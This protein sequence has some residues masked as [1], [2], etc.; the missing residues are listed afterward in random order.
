MAIWA[1]HQY[2][3]GIAALVCTLPLALAGCNV[4]RSLQIESEQSTGDRIQNWTAAQQNFWSSASQGSR[5]IPY[6]WYQALEQ[7]GSKS[8]FKQRAHL[9]RFNYPPGPAS[10][11]FPLG[12]AIDR[13]ADKALQATRLRWYADQKGDTAA[14]SEPWLGM[15]CGACHMGKVE[16]QGTTQIIFGGP[17]MGDFQSYVEALDNA[18]VATRENPE[19]WERFAARVL[20]GRDTVENRALLNTAFDRHLAWQLQAKRT[21]RTSIKYGY[22][23]VDAL[24]RLYNK[25]TQFA[26][27]TNFAGN[28]P[29]APVSYPFLWDIY[30]QKFVQWNGAA[31][32]TR[33]WKRNSSSPDLG[34]YG[35]NAGQVIGVFGEVVTQKR[36]IGLASS[37]N[38]KNLIQFER[39]IS[40]LQAPLWPSHFPAIDK[41]RLARGKALFAANCRDCH[42]SKEIQKRGQ[43]TEKMI[44]F[45]DT[46]DKNR[47][48][49][50]MACN[51]YV[52]EVPT[53]RLAGTF[54]T[55]TGREFRKREPGYDLL[56][57]MVRQAT[58][59]HL[60]DVVGGAAGR[61]FESV[62]SGQAGA[63]GRLKRI[64]AAEAHH[65]CLTA[66]HPTLGYKARP[67]D[68]IW[69]T[70]P[71]LHNGSVPTLYDLLLPANQR[72]TAFYLGTR[73]YDPQKVG[74]KT[75]SGNGNNFLFK[76]NQPKLGNGNGGHEYGVDKLS[77]E[78]KLS[79]LEYLKTL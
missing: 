35:R 17:S 16:Y 15:T 66:R 48:D 73:E 39:L 28:A 41:S 43:P 58:V 60:R 53:G 70:A 55:T 40:N 12:F 1:S 13:Q 46:D 14:T 47:T 20:N 69:A 31:R 21:N 7:A 23:R 27:V 11:D 37:L 76:V 77:E 65:T 6:A 32:N 22:G 44:L 2:R 50:Q 33:V 56:H 75:G 61:L 62:L 63:S 4:E 51:A 57:A 10:T 64:S 36:G 78:D 45:Q 74:F 52:Y 42:Q 54:N 26:G 67:L 34:A 5:L 9:A 71:Y 3:H 30:K 19:K 72:P 25:M 49:I 59:Y 38:S 24:G 79:L 29:S 8:L 18:L 68:G